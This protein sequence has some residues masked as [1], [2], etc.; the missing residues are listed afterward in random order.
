MKY[1]I[2]I[3]ALG[4]IN[5]LLL[6]NYAYAEG[7]SL[8][9]KPSTLQIRAKTPSEIYAPFTIINQSLDPID[10]KIILKSFGGAGDDSGKI[11]YATPQLA[12]ENDKDT[13]LQHIQIHSDGLET[14]NLSLGPKQE[15]KLQ[16][17]ISLDKNVAASDH[18]FS[19]I[20]LTT[21]QKGSIS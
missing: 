19:L 10:L 11:I 16:L 4:L 13:F 5:I 1:I 7:I 21:T 18:Y 3:F 12:S 17:W 8:K 6:P 14:K 15:K 2:I 9:I 20:F